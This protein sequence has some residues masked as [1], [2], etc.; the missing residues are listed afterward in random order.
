MWRYGFET[1]PAYLLIVGLLTLFLAI[2]VWQR[3]R[4]GKTTAVWLSAGL[5]GLLLGSVGTYALARLAGYE[6]QKALPNLPDF[7]DMGDDEPE[8]P[9]GEM[10]GGMGGDM[11]GTGGGM[12]G[13][14]GGMGG[15][16]IFGGPR[17]K[18]DLTNV[19]RKIELLTGDVGIT[20][21]TDQASAII[22]ALKA[23]EEA[24]SMSDDDA[25]AKHDEILALLDEDQQS[26][27]EA[28]GLPRRRGGGG[29]GGP[30]AED[31]NPFHQESSAAALSTLR[32]RF[33]STEQPAESSPAPAEETS[34]AEE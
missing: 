25:Q 23:I 2:F 7:A 14:G 3:H 30:P 29:P 11:E 31:A 21:T 5:V 20:F 13:M 12:G 26:Q 15:M 9:E 34:A 18:R 10:G 33:G 27:L 32:E 22:D 24:E 6:V 1:A 19:V 8:G 16:G 17:P 28:V 4:T